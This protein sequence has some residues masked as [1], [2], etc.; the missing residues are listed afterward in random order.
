MF[1]AL[2]PSEEAPQEMPSLQVMPQ[3][4]AMDDDLHDALL[5]EST[6]ARKIAKLNWVLEGPPSGS[7]SVGPSSPS[8]EEKVDTPVICEVPVSVESACSL[9]EE[10]GGLDRAVEAAIHV[11]RETWISF[12]MERDAGSADEGTKEDRA[13]KVSELLVAERYEAMKPALMGLL[14]WLGPTKPGGQGCDYTVVEFQSQQPPSLLVQR[15]VGSDDELKPQLEWL[16]KEPRAR[17]WEAFC[18]VMAAVS[19]RKE[20]NW[21][22]ANAITDDLNKKLTKLPLCKSKKSARRRSAIRTYIEKECVSG[23]GF[24]AQYLVLPSTNLCVAFAPTEPTPTPASVVITARMPLFEAFA[25]LGPP[26]GPLGIEAASREWCL[27]AG[28]QFAFQGAN[29]GADDSCDSSHKC[30]EDA[31][32][33]E[34]DAK[35]RDLL[36]SRKPVV[37]LEIVAALAPRELAKRQGF[38]EIVKAELA[39][40]MQE[41]KNRGEAVVFC[42][43]SDSPHVLAE[44]VYVRKPISDHGLRC[45]Y[46]RWRASADAPWARERAWADRICMCLQMP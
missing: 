39:R 43:G 16:R 17:A 27:K 46:L 7:T 22:E 40:V 33:L 32:T 44:K 21:L 31:E 9:Q 38:G 11:F 35:L 1:G 26:H 15:A 41:A 34:P 3:K 42:L 25:S 29:F 13:G 23:C 30:R 18:A 45:G 5:K 36:R 28:R 4:R 10:H 20:K 12:A 14:P 24:F 37:V 19:T 8:E 2:P 6:P